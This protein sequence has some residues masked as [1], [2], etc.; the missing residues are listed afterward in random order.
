DVD[1]LA[2]QLFEKSPKK[3]VKYSTEYSVNAG[4]NTVAQW[5]DFYKFL[6]TKYVDGNVKE[7]RPVPPGYKYIPP[8]VSQPGYGE[9]WYR[10]II[11]HTGD[12]FKAK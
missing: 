9:E 3:A 6:F 5:K 7:K 4:N 8:K 12:K 2:A 1:K 11:Q 10:I